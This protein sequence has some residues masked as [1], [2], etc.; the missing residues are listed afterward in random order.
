MYGEKTA[1]GLMWIN[2]AF[3]SASFSRRDSGLNAAATLGKATTLRPFQH[4]PGRTRHK[5]SE[6]L[7]WR[8]LPAQ[9]KGVGYVRAQ[10]HARLSELDQG[11]A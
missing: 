8:A 11:A 2:A 1:R 3:A 10:Q 6:E 9:W 7:V 5:G 4:R